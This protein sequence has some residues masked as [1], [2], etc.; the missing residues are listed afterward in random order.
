MHGPKFFSTHR[1]PKD[2]EFQLRWK[3]GDQA[4]QFVLSTIA[5]DCSKNLCCEASRTR[6]LLAFQPTEAYNPHKG[7]WLLK[8]PPSGV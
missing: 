1:T 6:L 3:K 5:D 4:K 2:T 8:L 7:V